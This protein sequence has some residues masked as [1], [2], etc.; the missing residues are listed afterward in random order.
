MRLGYVIVVGTFTAVMAYSQD[1]FSPGVA[2]IR[3]WVVPDPGLYGALYNY[4]FLT[5]NLSS[6]DGNPINSVTITGPN[7]GIATLRVGVHLNVYA[8][9]PMFVWVPSM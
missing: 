1:H 4:S 7:G 8:L 3:D 6:A 9:A 2:N 5:N